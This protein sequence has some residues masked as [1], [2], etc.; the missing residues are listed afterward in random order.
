MA[1]ITDLSDL[2]N[3]LSGGGAGPP[4]Y[5]FQTK[6]NRVGSAAA[7]NTVI[8]RWTSL[9]QY[10]GSP[11]AGAAPGTVSAPTNATPGSL[12]HTSPGG[13]R[14]KWLTGVSAAT[15]AIGTLVLYDRLLH[16][17]GLNGTTASPTAQTVGG[18]I[19]RYTGSASVGNQIWIEIYTLI[20]TTATTIS[21]SYTNQDG[22]S[23]T[24]E[25]AAIGGTG[26]REAQR[27]I[28]LTLAS[29]DTGVRSVGSVTLTAT[30]GTAGDF[31]VNIIRPLISIPIVNIGVSTVKDLISGLPTLPEIMSD[32]CLAWAWL[33]NTT[34]PPTLFSS[35]HMVEK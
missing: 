9:W 28:P 1:A 13:S 6:D 31:G 32:A 12:R 26:L 16:I 30:T 24:T 18:S 22:D 27:L 19:T 14:Q 7:S 25:L 29:G 11:S 3:L 34:S 33:P 15:S 35:L 21:A 10:L 4:E 2:V 20:G 17:S 8:G 5:L 23:K